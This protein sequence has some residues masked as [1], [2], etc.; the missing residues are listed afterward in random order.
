MHGTL[1]PLSP[2]PQDLAAGY[3]SGKLLLK[4]DGVGQLLAHHTSDT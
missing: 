1:P 2:P 4:L 3:M